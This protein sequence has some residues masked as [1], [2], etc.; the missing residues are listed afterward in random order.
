MRRLVG[1]SLVLWGLSTDMAHADVAPP[2]VEVSAYSSSV[3]V[4]EFAPAPA[5]A[6]GEQVSGP[7]M[8]TLAYGA[9]WLLTL[10][11]VFTL[12][13]RGGRLSAE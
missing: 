2:E 12:W 1:L 6:G 10:G 3:D 8:V 7:L 4:C 9:V 13:R 5:G 11:F